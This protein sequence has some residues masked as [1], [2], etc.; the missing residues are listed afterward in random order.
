VR[1]AF[2]THT[3]I[4]VVDA[5]SWWL[6]QPHCDSYCSY[7]LGAVTDQETASAAYLAL[8]GGQLDPPDEEERAD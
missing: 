1:E 6:D 4:A 2:E 8:I 7:L 5:A 3:L